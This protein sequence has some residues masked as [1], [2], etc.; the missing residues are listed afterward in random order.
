VVVSVNGLDYLA[1]ARTHDGV[2]V[3][4]YLPSSRRFT[5]DMTKVAGKA[6]KAALVQF[7]VESKKRSLALSI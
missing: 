5:V 6:A 2:T 4:A 1:A 3:I 7:G